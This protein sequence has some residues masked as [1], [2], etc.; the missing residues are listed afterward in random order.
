M[1][2][3]FFNNI[4]SFEAKA[5]F[6]TQFNVQSE[7]RNFMHLWTVV[8]VIPFKKIICNWK[9]QNI[10]GDSN[11]TFELEETKTVSNGI[12][13]LSVSPNG[14]LIALSINGEIFVKENDKDKTS[15]NNVSNHPF[16]DD[17]PFW[18]DDNTLGFLSDRNGQNEL[19]KVQ[20]TNQH[21]TA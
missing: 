17:N 4:P 20:I 7:N 6:K 2:L 15:T 18:I 1:Q 12:G 5:G 13:D 8:D 3:W 21:T 10:E 19:Y 9:Y 16:R 11:V 14:K